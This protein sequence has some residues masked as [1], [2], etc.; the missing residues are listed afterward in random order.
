MNGELMMVRQIKGT[1]KYGIHSKHHASLTLRGLSVVLRYFVFQ[2]L[3]HIGY[4]HK[5]LS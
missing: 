2:L 3:P 1:I 5:S 4:M